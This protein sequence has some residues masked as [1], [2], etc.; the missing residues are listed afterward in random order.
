MCCRCSWTC[1]TSMYRNRR[2]LLTCYN[3]SLLRSK[4][5]WYLCICKDYFQIRIIRLNVGLFYSGQV[6]KRSGTYLFSFQTGN[7]RIASIRNA[8]VCVNI[9]FKNLN[10]SFPERIMV[11]DSINN[12]KDYGCPK[13]VVGYE[14][15]PGIAIM[16]VW[17][18]FVWILFTGY[19]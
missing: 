6:T 4:H 15:W 17:M 14:L 10:Y 18:H 13:L 3:L 2:T 19:S 1:S 9:N 16:W 11:V 5:I 7:W 12:T 8:C